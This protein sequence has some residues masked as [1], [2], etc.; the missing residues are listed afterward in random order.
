MKRERNCDEIKRLEREM[1]SER[2]RR[3]NADLEIMRMHRVVDLERNN[4]AEQLAEV[5]TLADG[6]LAA[7]ALHKGANVGEGVW[8]LAIPVYSPTELYGRYSV[9]TDRVGEFYVIRVE[10]RRNGEGNV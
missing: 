4:A 10:E 8:E 9:R 1:Q 7:L 6:L 2:E 3:R 5:S